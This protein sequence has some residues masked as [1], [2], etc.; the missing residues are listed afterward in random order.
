MI[1]ARAASAQLSQRDRQQV[2]HAPAEA[3][4]RQVAAAGRVKGVKVMTKKS[5][6]LFGGTHSD[7]RL[8]R[9]AKHAGIFPDSAL[10]S[11]ASDARP[12]AEHSE[13]GSVPDSALLDSHRLVS[14]FI[15]PR[16]S[17]SWP[18]RPICGRCSATTVPSD[19][20]HAT[21]VQ[22][23]PRHTLPQHR[24]GRA[25]RRVGT[26]AAK[27]WTDLLVSSS[28]SRSRSARAANQA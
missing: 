21:P 28:R 1:K 7:T 3:V 8:L 18:V 5:P 12:V 22:R 14:D 23:G 27:M 19:P 15:A 20:P 6:A 10:K 16:L 2:G 4:E 26:N 13:G 17:G 9:V 25:Q 24:N 11:T